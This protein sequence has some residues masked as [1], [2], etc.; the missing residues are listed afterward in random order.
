VG[1]NAYGAGLNTVE[2][3]HAFTQWKLNGKDGYGYNV[4]P[5]HQWKATTP[6]EFVAELNTI[7]GKADFSPEL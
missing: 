5:Q 4:F 7:L 6:Q 1:G 3:S 2:G